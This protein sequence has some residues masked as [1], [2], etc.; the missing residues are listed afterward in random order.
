MSKTE[1]II[2]LGCFLL[3]L[4][5]LVA[6]FFPHQR[7]WGVNLLHYFSLEFRIALSAIGFVIL[8]PQVNKILAGFFTRLFA[9]ITE[10]F[11]KINRYL[12]YSAISLLSLIP[13]W[14]LGAKTPLLGD[15]Y[16][17]ANDIAI[18]GILEISEPLDFY[19]H[20]LVARLF[21]LDG[22]TV[23]K[24]LSCVAGAI[25]I[26]LVFLI[27][28][29]LG[30]DGKEKL[31]IFSIL[32]TMGANQ[33]FFGYI[34]SYSFVYVALLAYFFFGI[35]Y[36]RQKS[37]FVWPC[38]FLLFA[39]GFHLAVFLLIPSL[40]FLGLAKVP[41]S[42][43]LKAKRVKFANLASSMGVILLI[44]VGVYFLKTHT[45]G[46]PPQSLLIHPFGDGESFYS[47]FSLAHLVDFVNHQ[48]LL[49]P[50][51]LVLWIALLILFWKSINHKENV[52]KFLIWVIGCSFGL[53]LLVDP[54]LG[55]ARDWDLF[56]FAGLGITLLGLYLCINAFRTLHQ[57]VRDRKEKAGELNQEPYGSWLSRVTLVL[58]T[59]SVIFTLPW[60]LVNASKD[61]AIVRFEDLLKIDEKR[62]AYG[63]ETLACYLCDKGNHEKTVEYW[64]KAI[65]IT[66][67]ARYFGGLGYAY[68][69]LKKYNQAIEA[70]SRGI[71]MG[72][73]RIY[74]PFLHNSLAICL[75]EVG[76]YDEAVSEL[77]KAID[78]D[79]E[80]ADYYY[81][82]G[83]I[84]GLAGR[85]QE[86]VPYFETALKLDPN[87]AKTY[88]MLGITYGIIG[89]K[90]EAEKN[91]MIYLK[92]MP[93]NAPA[94][95]AIMDSLKIDVETNK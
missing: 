42:V 81:V 38:L 79:P 75:A 65:A 85:Y 74:L 22:Y 80:N 30:K 17:R 88:K 83:H 1:K 20:L 91:L 39:I 11:K 60:M 21:G 56:A 9:R 90:E 50:V 14:I 78:Y 82:L 8:I 89:K 57:T 53:A 10:K 77:R 69:K 43:K 40:F 27:C 13:F 49:S 51:N 92:L 24:I 26:F 3:I 44:G 66:P 28:D 18:G 58:F 94:V 76:R 6:S 62:A 64:K 5:H 12:I 71:Q 29:L 48:I 19:F 31:F 36:L 16:I 52:V 59:T 33:L 45:R 54:K 37:K 63:Y 23:Y 86:A 55:Y 46:E 61:K 15:G 87:N 70:I 47:F 72:A 32:V 84:L 2:S 4:L 93:N 25:Y 35:R 34:E 68:A 67:N 95:K 73:D 41:E 7:L